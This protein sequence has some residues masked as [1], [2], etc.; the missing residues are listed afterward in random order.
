MSVGPGAHG[1]RQRDV[2]SG[3]QE[4][5]QP[6]HRPTDAHKG[7]FG[8]VL[9]IAGRQGMSGAAVL[10]GLGALRG[11]A[12][13]VTVAAPISIQPIV[14]AAEPSYLTYGCPEDGEGG[15]CDAAGPALL[16]RA[17]SLS[18]IV[19]GP[20]L[21][22]SPGVG[23]VVRLLVTKCARPMVLDAD[24]LNVISRAPE[25]DWSAAGARIVTPHPGELARLTK[26]AT[27]QIQAARAERAAEFAR[28][29]GVIVVLKGAG[30]IVTDGQRTAV[31]A[32]GNSGMATGGSG[33]VLAG[34]IGALLAQGLAPYDAARLGVHLHG[35]AGDL[36]ATELSGPGMIASDLPRCLGRAWLEYL[37]GSE[38]P[39]TV[40]PVSH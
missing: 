14:A 29:H 31:N 11:G 20:G 32:T 2:M 10:A 4:L 38:P 17:L 33:D 18:A 1:L 16:E 5:P 12:G 26:A 28:R 19:L 25:F 34:L 22:Q 9:V 39:E 24:A 7:T 8:H 30:T 13:L 15:L 6:P 23:H 27:S 37:D 36:A 35:L 40:N 21:G 3:A